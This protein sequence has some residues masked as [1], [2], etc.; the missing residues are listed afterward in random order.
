MCFDVYLHGVVTSEICQGSEKASATGANGAILINFHRRLDKA[1]LHTCSGETALD[2]H[3]K[4]INR[5]FSELEKVVIAFSM[6]S[7]DKSLCTLAFLPVHSLFE[8]NR[9]AGLTS[10]VL[11][12]CFVW[13][14]KFLCIIIGLKHAPHPPPPPPRCTAFQILLK[15]EG[16]S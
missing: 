13:A 4:V 8:R 11:Q 15:A 9:S 2:V 16:K 14:C 3:G 5:R 6:T 1:Y 12:P 10:L 7:R